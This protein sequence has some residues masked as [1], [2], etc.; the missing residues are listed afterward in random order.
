MRAASGESRS[1]PIRGVRGFLA[2]VD[3]C[4]EVEAVGADVVDLGAV[5]SSARAFQVRASGEG[6]GS[7]AT[8]E[9]EE[10]A[11]RRLAGAD[12]VEAWVGHRP[13]GTRRAR[14]RIRAADRDLIA[15]LHRG[16]GRLVARERLLGLAATNEPEG[17]RFGSTCDGGEVEDGI[18]GA[19]VVDPGVQNGAA[20]EDSLAERRKGGEADAVSVSEI[21]VVAGVAA[22]VIPRDVDA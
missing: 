17:G 6:V 9:A 11:E 3:L 2:V 12:G 16:A 10:V 18:A 8:G 20:N 22:G 7:E 13:F 4:Q 15:G 5:E 19:E 14:Q 21:G 1:K